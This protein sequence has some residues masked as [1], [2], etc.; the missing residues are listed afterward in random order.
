MLG[1][2]HQSNATSS[3][4]YLFFILSNLRNKTSGY[5]VIY[6][7]TLLPISFRFLRACLSF[8]MSYGFMAVNSQKF[9]S[10]LSYSYPLGF[11]KGTLVE[12]EDL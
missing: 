12:R 4:M 9:P 7:T 8:L 3:I 1:L 2:V 6:V 5:R 10:Q 11:F